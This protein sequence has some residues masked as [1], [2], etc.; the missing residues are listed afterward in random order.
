MG[1]F[2][3]RYDSRVV[4]YD[5]RGFIRLA[6]DLGSRQAEGETQKS[7][8]VNRRNLMSVVCTVQQGPP[9]GM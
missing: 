8:K 6:T 7:H 1:Y 9:R 2:K 4:N 3:V 5:R